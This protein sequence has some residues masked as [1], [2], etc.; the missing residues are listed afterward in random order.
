MPEKYVPVPPNTPKSSPPTAAPS[1]GHERNA[2]GRPPADFVIA[3]AG[4][5]GL[6]L[7][8]ALRTHVGVVAEVYDSAE[9]F[10]DDVGAGMG[11]Y[12]NGLR[13]M[14]DIGIDLF[15]SVV[16]G[17]YPYLYRRWDRHDGTE[18]TVAK[19]VALSKEGGGGAGGGELRSFGIRRSR[20]QR[21]LHDAAVG[22]GV[23]IR[24]GKRVSGVVEGD[25]ED[26]IVRVSFEDGTERL[27]RVLFGADGCRS[28][29]RESVA[30]D[31]HRLRYTGV[32]CL[33]VIADVPRR[34]QGICFPASSTTG[35]HAVFFPTGASEQCFQFH[36]PVPADRS[37]RGV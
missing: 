21:E 32:T 13:V 4:I 14:R 17:G 23:S 10:R 26:G 33:I 18:A 6:V 9:E 15:R 28:A 8:L 16:G 7:A 19:E 1:R 37:D 35:C 3:G 2:D 29:V 31:A 34:D 25:G 24:F 27:T 22:L 11:M 36:F 5:V 20:L 30:G 12:P